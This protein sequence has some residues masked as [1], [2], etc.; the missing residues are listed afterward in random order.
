MDTINPETSLYYTVVCPIRTNHDNVLS[1]LESWAGCYNIVSVMVCDTK[2]RAC[3]IC[4]TWRAAHEINN[5]RD[6]T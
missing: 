3:E 6:F 2:K 1:A 5:E 4:E